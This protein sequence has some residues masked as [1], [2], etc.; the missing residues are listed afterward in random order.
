MTDTDAKE[1]E[2]DAENTFNEAL[3][4]I[5]LSRIGAYSIVEDERDGIGAIHIADA[6]A[7]A[8]EMA[9]ERLERHSTLAATILHKAK[10]T[11]CA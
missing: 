11:P 3:T 1:I 8:L 10:A 5:M 9:A 2:R 4:L 6:I 7:Q